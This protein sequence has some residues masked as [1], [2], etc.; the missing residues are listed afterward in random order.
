MS[1]SR[2][3]C[4]GVNHRRAPVELREKVAF[5]NERI[6]DALST[7]LRVE[8]ISEAM[9]LSTCNRVELYA[10]GDPDTTTSVANTPIPSR[11]RSAIAAKR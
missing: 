7:L 4:V 8:G 10:A 5:A 1:G 9:V 11:L 6:D 2:L 3:I